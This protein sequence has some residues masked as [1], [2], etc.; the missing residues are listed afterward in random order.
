VWD[1]AGLDARGALEEI[2]FVSALCLMM[3]CL[4]NHAN[5]AHGAM[6]RTKEDSA[7]LMEKRTEVCSMGSR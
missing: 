3:G 7:S 1:R 2:W 5:T 4:I 6:L